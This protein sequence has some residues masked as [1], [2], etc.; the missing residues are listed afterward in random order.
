MGDNEPECVQA[1]YSKHGSQEPNNERS[2]HV[3]SGKY[4]VHDEGRPACGASLSIVRLEVIGLNNIAS[5][6]II[7]T[8]WDRRSGTLQLDDSLAQ[9]RSVRKNPAA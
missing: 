4:N 6:A 1:V 3:G 9:G 7:R 8:G 5:A 2:T